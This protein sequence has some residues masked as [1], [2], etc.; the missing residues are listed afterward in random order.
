MMKRMNETNQS[1]H[2]DDHDDPSASIDALVGPS[3]SSS[4]D[5]YE[6]SFPFVSA[7]EQSNSSEMIDDPRGEPINS[8]NSN[9]SAGAIS[10]Y[11]RS[12]SHVLTTPPNPLASEDHPDHQNFHQT[13]T[14]IPSAGFEIP[15]GRDSKSNA[16]FT[17]DDPTPMK[18][19]YAEEK[20]T[21]SLMHD[22][23][24][25]HSSSNSST[26][27]MKAASGTGKHPCTYPEC[28]KV[29]RR[30]RRRL[31]TSLLKLISSSR[32]L[33]IKVP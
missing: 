5:R 29:R 30:R 24:S 27:E 7:D 31:F 4:I 13:F 20:R 22:E 18:Y 26:R 6:S 28:T 10:P 32:S 11:L 15:A 8:S 23:N 1:M 3:L 17:F 9:P 12:T 33:P 21:I 16:V 14:P 2:L 25:N 19:S